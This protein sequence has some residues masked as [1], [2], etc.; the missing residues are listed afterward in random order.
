MRFYSY[1]VRRDYGFA[2]NPF[3]G[4][5]TLA[6]CKPKIRKAALIED[7]IIG[8]GSKKYGR[9]LDLIFA[10]Q[11][12]EKLTFNSYWNDSRFQ[13]KKPVMNGSLKQMYGDNI[14]YYDGVEW[15]Q[16]DS[17]HSYD[18]GITNFHNLTRDTSVDAVLLSERFYYFGMNSIPVPKEIAEDIIKKG[19]GHKIIPNDAGMALIAFLNG[20]YHQA[21]H[22]D[23]EL[24][25]SIGF[26]RYDGRS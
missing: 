12:S 13:C 6:T 8:T 18:G 5:C 25:R 2:P 16:A 20:R 19:P 15:H 14:Y 22:G 7:W 24:F 4:V 21:Y 11:V 1:V 3:D 26:D 9:N 10:M 23:P 17:H